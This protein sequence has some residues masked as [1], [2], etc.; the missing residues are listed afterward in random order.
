MG[1]S[2][3]TPFFINKFSL[4]LFF[5]SIASIFFLSFLSTSLLNDFKFDVSSTAIG[6]LTLIFSSP[7][8]IRSFII[9][10]SSELSN[11]II[12]LSVSISAIKSPAFTTSPSLTSHFDNLPSDIVGERAGINT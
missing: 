2:E 6:S 11:S 1:S 12:A 7:S 10:P 8:F 5:F 3:E 9:V 4:F